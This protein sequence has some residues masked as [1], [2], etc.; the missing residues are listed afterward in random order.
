MRPQN[1]CR[2]W[3]AAVTKAIRCQIVDEWSS[4]GV[5]CVHVEC[6]TQNAGTGVKIHQRIPH[7]E[8]A[9]SRNHVTAELNAFVDC[10]LM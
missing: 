5:K 6:V 9:G 2:V 8:A 1:G 4:F 3:V 10:V 7:G